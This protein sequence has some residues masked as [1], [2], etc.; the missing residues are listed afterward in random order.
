MMAMTV[1]KLEKVIHVVGTFKSCKSNYI[2]VF[3]CHMSFF[4]G[5]LVTDHLGKDMVEVLLKLNIYVC[6]CLI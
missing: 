2:C 5:N 4:V 1:I 3:H 6:M